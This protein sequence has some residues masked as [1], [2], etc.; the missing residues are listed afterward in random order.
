[1]MD[2]DRGTNP[3]RAL[4]LYAKCYM[5]YP[6]NLIRGCSRLWN[7]PLTYAAFGSIGRG[8]AFRTGGTPRLSVPFNADGT[9]RIIPYN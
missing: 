6:S 3:D 9:S 8:L 5:R 4:L 2:D 1:M 7:H